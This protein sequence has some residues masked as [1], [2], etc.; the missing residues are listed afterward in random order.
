M[1]TMKQKIFD[2][3]NYLI[4]SNDVERLKKIIVRYELFKISNKI[5]GDIV[6]CGV[7]KGIG[8]IF[9]LKMLHLFDHNSSKKVIG[10]DTFSS[11]PKT[12]LNFEKKAAKLFIKEAKFRKDNFKILNEKIK[13]INLE[14]RSE[15]I[16]GDIVKTS[17]NYSK[18][19]RGF[20]ISLL[21]IDLDTY[22]GTKSS[23]ENFFPLVSKGG[24]VIFD[25]YGER[26]W[27]ETEAIDNYFKNTEYKIQK[28]KNSYYPTAFL[29]KK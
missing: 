3:Y 5:P 23:L 19:N 11:F 7:F 28:T 6:E 12:T 24:I 18:K 16:K 2:A 4:E 14:K 9:W 26:G 25:E 8:H 1:K 21:H 22:A 10:F 15:L 17:K 29:I 13:D 20:R 27:G